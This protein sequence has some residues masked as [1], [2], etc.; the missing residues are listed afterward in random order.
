MLYS[1]PLPVMVHYVVV[2]KVEQ[3]VV[4]LASL[5]GTVVVAT[6]VARLIVHIPL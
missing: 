1:P 5:G 2:N 3:W 6:D 4:K